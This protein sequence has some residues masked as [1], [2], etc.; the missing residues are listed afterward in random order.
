MALQTHLLRTAVLY[1]VKQE[2]EVKDKNETN[3]TA[4]SLVDIQKQILDYS[5]MIFNASQQVG[6]GTMYGVWSVAY[7]TLL[8][9]TCTCRMCVDLRIIQVT[10]LR[11]Y[12]MIWLTHATDDVL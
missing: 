10:N 8:R 4:E 12:S 5:G 3:T 6:N 11:I 7:T 1:K 9:Y 2:S